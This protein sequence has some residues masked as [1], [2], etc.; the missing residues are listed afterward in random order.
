VILPKQRPGARARGFVRACSP[1]LEDHGISQN[2]FLTFI[3]KF[4]RATTASPILR[5]L[6]LG[7]G[8]MGFMLHVWA[9]I[10]SAVLQSAVG[11]VMEN[12]KR[13]CGNNS[14]KRTRSRPSSVGFKL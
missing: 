8:A 14:I 11:L 9:I 2:S 4:D 5:F 6:N 3:E 10:T 12:Q 13:Y 1:V 7:A